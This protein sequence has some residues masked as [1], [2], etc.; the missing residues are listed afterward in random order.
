[1]N[2]INLVEKKKDLLK[3]AKE[4]K[5]LPR[6]ERNFMISGLKGGMSKRSDSAV[7]RAWEEDP[8][9]MSEE[10]MKMIALEVVR[11][12]LLDLHQEI[13]YDVEHQLIDWKKLQDG[14]LR[15]EQHFI[16][17]KLSKCKILVGKNGSKIG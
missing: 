4:F 16:S 6:Y 1:M 13:L 3:V 15:I 7:R 17:S 8:F 12:R 11:E 5:D 10:V 9:T 14:F 2:K